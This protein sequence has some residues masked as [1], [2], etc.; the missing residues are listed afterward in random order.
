METKPPTREETL[1]LLKEF[2][3][4]DKALRHALAVEAVMRHA[5]EN[6]VRTSKSGA[7]SG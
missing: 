2:N 7:S 3:H 5:R 6:V 1:Q 4:T